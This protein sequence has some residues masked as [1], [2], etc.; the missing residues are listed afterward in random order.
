MF[1]TLT[2]V[3]IYI[4]GPRSADQSV[5]LNAF[6]RISEYFFLFYG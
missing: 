3:A 1:Q 4:F 6:Y 5:Y 2:L